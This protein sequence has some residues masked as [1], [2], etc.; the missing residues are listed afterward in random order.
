MLNIRYHNTVV[1]VLFFLLIISFLY[2][3]QIAIGSDLSEI[4]NLLTPKEQSWIEHHK[5]L[6][7]AGPKEFPPFVFFEENGE[8]K[9]ISHD[10][11]MLIMNK[12]GV[13]LVFEKAL[14]WTE[15]LN[16][17]KA[18]EI[19]I[20]SCIAKT[21]EREEFLIFSDPYLIFPLVIISRKDS[22][23]I[24]G[25]DDLKGL[26]VAII[27]KNVVYEWLMKDNINFIECPVQDSLDALQ[28][29]SVGNAEAHI[30][31]L[32]SATYLIEKYGLTNL[33]V[34][35]P[36]KYANYNLYLGIRRDFPE[37]ASIIN[38]SMSLLSQ[39]QHAE[40][41]NRWLSIRYEYGISRTDVITWIILIICPAI[42]IIF[43]VIIGNRRLKREIYE[44][45][46]AEKELLES[47][48]R[49]KALH[50]ASFGGIAIHDKGIILECNLGLSEMTGYSLAELIGVNGLLLISK[51][52][53]KYVLN[54]I[55]AGYEKPYEA[56][57]VR[58][59]GEEFP[60]RLEARNI[61]Y[62]GKDVR[63]VE[64]RDITESKQ[65]EE[66]QKELEATN[67]RLHKAESLGK[68]AGGIAHL[69]NNYL[70]V[71]LGNL[72][73]TLEDLPKQSLIR[74]NIMKAI[75]ATSRCADI[76][77]SMLTYLG[78]SIIKPELFD[79]SE[80]CH[81][82]LLNVQ[83]S[84]HKNISIEAN[85]IDAELLVHANESQ[86][87]QIMNHLITN[88]YEAIGKD[89]G[90]IN[91]VTKKVMA[92]DISKFDLFPVSSNPSSNA[93]LCLEVTDT[94]CGIP[95]KDIHKIFDPFFTTKFTGRGLGLPVISGIVKSWS[96][97]IGVKSEVGHGSSFM[98]FLPLSNDTS[99]RPT[100]KL[101]HTLEPKTCSTILLVEDHAMLRNMATTMLKKM[102][103]EVISAVNGVEAVEL[104][105][106]HTDSIGC[107]IT[108]LSMPELDGWETLAEIRKIKPDIPAILASGYDE[109]FAMSRIYSEKPQ[110]FLHKPYSK[111]DLKSAVGQA[112]NSL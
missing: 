35:A 28:A 64:F 75:K 57:G 81:K 71:V 108:D 22:K 59:N 12:L 94:G 53:R 78:Q 101:S 79:I 10:Y 40:I 13:K 90:R 33:K 103:F 63:V 61:P 84:N 76:S 17:A 96:G 1:H 65:A 56:I 31:N 15:V 58:K 83:S 26:K 66:K 38:K 112:L 80:F 86:M 48:M 110:A 100:K 104:F 51:K 102:G 60:M 7:V 105:R 72:E 67:L 55:S 46:R 25:L 95:T 107:L 88:A 97:M 52:S 29:V 62:K 89:K 69:F 19:D 82:N 87:Q 92:S 32:A 37:L 4:S 18:K 11:L 77:G 5:I 36:T 2:P 16:K 93:Y 49:F 68:M 91:I 99:I 47:E 39:E 20:I 111:A 21:P 6:R 44:R 30:E 70:A 9:G 24:G 43:F 8:V 50:N 106:Q 54:K 41:R 27:K 14:P 74:N 98:I 45:K 85:L 109:A 23:F 3:Y 42:I 34:A 73:L